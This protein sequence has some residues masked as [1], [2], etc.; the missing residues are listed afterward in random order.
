MDND[1]ASSS[2]DQ[3]HPDSGQLREN[4]SASRCVEGHGII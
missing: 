1:K 2:P 3:L 4:S